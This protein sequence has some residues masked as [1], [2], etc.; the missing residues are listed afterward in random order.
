MIHYTA[1][2]LFS[3]NVPA[4]WCIEDGCMVSIVEG[5]HDPLH[6][7]SSA[8][9]PCVQSGWRNIFLILYSYDS[10]LNVVLH[11][12]ANSFYP[13]T[14]SIASLCMCSCLFL[15]GSMKSLHIYS[16][17]YCCFPNSLTGKYWYRYSFLL[18]YQFFFLAIFLYWYRID[19]FNYTI[20]FFLTHSLCIA[21]SLYWYIG[22]SVYRYI[23]IAP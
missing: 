17:E 18:S 22:I 3:S 8:L 11:F 20:F 6:S 2:A 1:Q 7:I 13:K 14:D 21:I 10:R 15:E 12:N 5:H 19:D 9:P 16:I 4:G 23:G